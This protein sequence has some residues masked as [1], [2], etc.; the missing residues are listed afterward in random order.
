MK[1]YKTSGITHF[2][3]KAVYAGSFDPVTNGHLWLIEQGVKLFDVL[4]IAIGVNPDKKY[5]FPLT[6][7]IDMLKAITHHTLNTYIDTFENQYLVNYAKSIKAPYI[8]RGIRTEGDYEYERAMRHINSDLNADITTIFLIPPREI[9]E[10]SSSFV[11]GL[12][13]P[14]GWEDVVK[15]Y[16]PEFVQDKLAERFH[17]A[18]R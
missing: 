2:M 10:I 17:N 1:A 18:P 11:K 16:V 8:L 6:E 14:Q 12:I 13:G 7:R 15:K 3:K 4:V 5:T 9:A